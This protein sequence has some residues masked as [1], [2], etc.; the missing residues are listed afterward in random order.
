MAVRTHLSQGAK[1][2]FTCLIE[3]PTLS[4]FVQHCLSYVWQLHQHAEGR[5][6]LGQ[7]FDG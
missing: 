7:C 6:G 5:K 1:H 3:S 2:V 4:L